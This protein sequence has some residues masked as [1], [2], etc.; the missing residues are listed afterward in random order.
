VSARPLEDDRA[1]PEAVGRRLVWSD[2]FD[3]P[4]GTPADPSVWSH[5]LGD[6]S[7]NGIPGWGN[8]ELQHYTPGTEN[9][10]LDGR[11]NLVITA[12]RLP[13][14]SRAPSE[15]TSARLVTKG[16]LDFTHG[17]IETR[18]HVPRG[19]GLW[20]A[21]WALGASIDRVGWPACGE[22]DVMEHVGR[23][24]RRLYAAVHGPGYSGD[25]GYVGSIQLA[26]DVADDY[27]VFAVEWQPGLIVWYLD[28]EPYHRVSP[29]DLAR[30]S[31]VFEHPFYLLLNLA[32]GG[33]FGGDVPDG[34]V[35]PQEL[36]V[37]YVRVFEAVR[38]G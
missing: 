20:P 27:H 15:Y 38:P 9:A 36:V 28:G 4:A 25:D 11:G 16:R 6:G 13:G 3:G 35:F 29:R 26:V 22:I 1:H 32:V 7:A 30:H 23:E 18:A 12:R 34:T 17:R 21:F 33:T 5:E 8:S 10:A 2:E 19:A 37:D 24:P 14:T 31:W